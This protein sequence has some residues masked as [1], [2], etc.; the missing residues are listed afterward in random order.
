MENVIRVIG[1]PK[2]PILAET[3]LLPILAGQRPYVLDPFAFPIMIEKRSSLADPMWQMLDGHKFAA[4]VLMHNPDN[5]E[6]REFYAST[7]FGS[8]FIERMERN[9]KLTGTP[10]GMYLYLPRN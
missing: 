2:Q 4:V 10:E 3:P 9:Y 7:H 6:G 5:D 1:T 8:A